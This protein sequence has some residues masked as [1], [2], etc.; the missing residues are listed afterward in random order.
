MSFAKKLARKRR[1][2]ER[3]NTRDDIKIA[4]RAQRDVRDTYLRQSYTEMSLRVGTAHNVMIILMTAAHKVFRF[5]KKRL[6][7][8][9][10]HMK[11]LIECLR[12]GYVKLQEL[13]QI[14]RDEAKLDI[15]DHRD[16]RVPRD[17]LIQF[18][19]VDEM[20]MVFLLGLMD[21]YGYKSKR[22]STVY[23]EAASIS[24]KLESNEL[25]IKD[26]EKILQEDAKFK[27]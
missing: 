16:K 18:H 26:L 25:E 14:L 24:E 8:L 22:L 2:T 15:Q 17:K 7:R 13:C 19:V 3:R 10:E 9:C 11:R 1:I 27:D 23:A 20:S 6:E 12:G 4:E 21:E 5:G